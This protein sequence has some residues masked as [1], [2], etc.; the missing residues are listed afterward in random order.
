MFYDRCELSVR[1][2]LKKLI[3][4]EFSCIQ[5]GVVFRHQSNRNFPDVWSIPLPRQISTKSFEYVWRRNL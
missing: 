5:E 3:T 1:P 4:F 2:Q